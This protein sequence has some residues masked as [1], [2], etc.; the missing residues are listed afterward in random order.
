MTK[1]EFITQYDLLCKGHRFE[2][3]KE[4][5]DAWF[6]KVQHY[7][8]DDW[9]DAVSTLLCGPRFPLLDPALAVLDAA[10][11]QRKRT[12]I[13]K[14]KKVAERVSDQ[15]D[16]GAVA[17][18]SS[19]LFQTIKVFCSRQQVRS[20]QL[21]V[22]SNSREQY[23]PEQ[24]TRELARLQAEEQR[25][26]QEYARLMAGLSQQECDAFTVRYGRAVAA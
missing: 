1:G 3:T 8:L 23:T 10:R 11:E 19:S 15:I 20:Q 26:T 13:W 14:D 21:L 17:T 25:L 22:A 12:E 16:R 9:A 7:A 4:Q 5:G 2:P 18:L 6:R 24:R